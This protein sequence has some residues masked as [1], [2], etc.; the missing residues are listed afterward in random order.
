M[1][2]DLLRWKELMQDLDFLFT[3][4]AMPARVTVGEMDC[5][6]VTA[7]CRLVRR[8]WVAEF[9]AC[10]NDA[11]PLLNDDGRQLYSLLR[12]APVGQATI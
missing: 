1:N 8:G 9:D 5:D 10:D 7:L 12:S 6:T 4:A 2:R 3:F 11:A